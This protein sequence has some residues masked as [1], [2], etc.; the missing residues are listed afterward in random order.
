[1]RTRFQTRPQA[2]VARS[3][4]PRRKPRNQTDPKSNENKKNNKKHYAESNRIKMVLSGEP[5]ICICTKE[6]ETNGDRSMD[7]QPFIR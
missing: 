4:V 7:I 2:A 5:E 3:R 1:M 6:V